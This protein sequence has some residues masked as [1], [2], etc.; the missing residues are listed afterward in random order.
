MVQQLDGIR[1]FRTCRS[2]RVNAHPLFTFDFGRAPL[3]IRSPPWDKTPKNLSE[4]RHT[5]L[6]EPSP[7]PQDQIPA[8][9][10]CSSSQAPRAHPKPPDKSKANPRALFLQDKHKLKPAIPAGI[11]RTKHKR[12][13]RTPQ[14]NYLNMLPSRQHHKFDVVQAP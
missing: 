6:P 8:A 7:P 3:N 5:A 14:A 2:S 9:S 13:R 4:N 12:P 10:A 1:L 11:L